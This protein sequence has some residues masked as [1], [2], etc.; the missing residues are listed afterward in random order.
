M[1]TEWIFLIA[2]LL[3]WIGWGCVLRLVYL[4]LRPYFSGTTLAATPAVP[5]FAAAFC[6]LVAETLPSASGRA[7]PV[8]IDIPLVWIQMSYQAVGALLCLIIAVVRAAQ[9]IMAV[10]QA[11]RIPHVWASSIWLVFAVLFAVLYTKTGGEVTVFR[12]MIGLTATK[13]FVIVLLVAVGL[14]AMAWSARNAK[15]RSKVK[16]FATH[17][18][19]VTGTV[20]FGFPFAWLLVTSF[21]EDKDISTTQGMVWVPRV[22]RTVEY[23]DPKK[24]F[25]VMEFRGAT[26]KGNVQSE[27]AGGTVLVEVERPFNIRGRR[28]EVPRTSLKEIPRLAKVVEFQRNGQTAQGYVTEELENGERVV[29]VQSPPAFAGQVVQVAFADAVPVRDIGLRT[30]NYGEMLEWLPA[31]SDNGLKFLKNTLVLVVMSV[32]GT[33]LSSVLVGY[34]FSRLRFPGRET[35]FGVLLATMMLPGAVTMLPTFLVFRSLGWIDTLY[36]I[37]VPTFFAGAFNVFL[38]RQFFR[39]IPM[40]LEDAAKID[41]CNYLRTLFQVMV[42]QIKPVLATIAI[43][44]FMGAWNNF[45][46]PLIYVSTPE[47]MPIAYALQMFQTERGSEFALMMAFATLAT[48]PTVLLFFFA[49]K[50]FI[51]GVQFSGLGG[52]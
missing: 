17:I 4:L 9:A 37:W 1:S 6:L 42:P 31:E 21:K 7:D 51:E 10:N 3:T 14:F 27:T 16:G 32:I 35:L 36:P 29:T 45:M 18:V 11:M 44:T 33:L 48:I 30:E 5:A 20:V 39:T 12:G 28:I 19:L 38:L 43:W 13:L 34:G 40:E 15:R 50:Y 23:H 46:G 41:G 52:K 25:Y 26:I 49:Q 2:T 22:Q 47:N 8:G 24:P